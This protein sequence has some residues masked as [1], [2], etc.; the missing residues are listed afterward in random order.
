MTFNVI[1]GSI[2]IIGALLVPVLHGR[3]Q[4]AYMLALPFLSLLSLLGLPYGEYGQIVFFDYNLTTIRVDKLSLVFV[5]IFHI[6]ALLSVLYALHVRDKVQHV[7]GL[8]YAGS[9]I[10]AVFAGDLISPFVYWELTAVSSA[11]LIWARRTERSYQAGMR[12]LII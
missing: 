10:S 11:F 3:I 5:I 7:A 4:A 9:A 8:I 1:P 2:L 12:Y 6:A